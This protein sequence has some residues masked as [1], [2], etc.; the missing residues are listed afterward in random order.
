MTWKANLS[1]NRI[2][3]NDRLRL[4][5]NLLLSATHNNYAYLEKN[6]RPEPAFRLANEG[7]RGVFV[8][9]AQIEPRTGRSNWLDS[10]ATTNWAGCWNSTR[11][12]TPG[13]GPW[14]WT[15]N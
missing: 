8:P 12:A 10:R 6:L 5:L 2:L 9:A 15:A 11:W 3:M 7:N 4:G 1:Y 13:S 14:W